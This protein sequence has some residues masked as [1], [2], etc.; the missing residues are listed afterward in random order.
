MP[1]HAEA[2]EADDVE[3]AKDDGGRK[4]ELGVVE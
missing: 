1:G 3:D 2:E 4:E